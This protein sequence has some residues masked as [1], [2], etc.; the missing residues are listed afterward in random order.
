MAERIEGLSIE[1]D[2]ET[3]K[4]NSGLKDLKSQLTV[5]NSEMKANMSAF[6]RSD[7]SIEKYETRLTGLNKKLEVQRAVV[8]NARKTYEKMVKEHGEGTEEA[9]KAAKEYNNQVASLNNLSRYVE[10]VEGDLAQLREEQRIANS[11]WTKMGGHLDN[12]GNKMTIFGDKV[13]SAGSTMSKTVTPAVLGI[14][15]AAGLVAGSYEDSATRIQNSLGLTAEEAKEL[16]DVSRNIYNDGFGESAEEIDTALLQVKQ[17]IRDV[18]NEDLERI[19]EKAFLLADT[20]ESDVNEVTRAGN[21]IIKGFGI[22]ADEAFDL[23]A[24][25]AQNGLNFSNEMFDNLSEYSGLFASM[26]FS[27]E[28]Y[29][30]LLQKGSEAGIYNLDY[31]NDVMKEF[32]IRVK[33]GSD[34][35]K[36][37]MGQMSDSTQD[38]W[39]EFQKGDKTVKDVSNAVLKELEG[40]DNQVAANQIGV[41]LFG[42]KFEDLESEA[43]YS[44]GGIGEGIE[45]VDGTMDEMTKNAE[46]NIS[47]QWKATWREAKEILL[48]VGETLLDFT[49]EVLP[50][51]K[52]GVEDVTEWFSELDE[53]GKRNIV[54]LGGMAAAAGPVLTVV[55]GLS[56]GIGGLLKVTGGLTTAIGKKNGKG[57]AGAISLLSR[58]GVAGLAIAGVAGI[59]IG[60]AD[61]IKKSKKS[62]EVNLD[63]AQSLSDQAVQLESSAET[64]DKLSGKAKISNDEL[65]ELNDLN[66]R[67]S[68]STNPGEINELQK[69]YEKLAKKSGLSKDEL[70]YLFDANKDIIDQAPNVQH[71]VSESGNAFVENTNAVKEYVNSLYEMSKV[72][73]ENER[74]IALENEREI[75][76]EIKEEKEAIEEVEKKIQL[77]NAASAMEQQEIEKRLSKIKELYN[78]QNVSAKEKE[79]LV[80]EE[81]A[82]RDVLTGKEQEARLDLKGQLETKKES[83][84][85]SEEELEKIKA[86][87][88]EMANII[89]KQVGIN[90]EGEKGL[91]QLDEKLAKNQQELAE[92]DK[93]LEKN[94]VLNEKDRERR[95]TLQEI[96]GQQQE[97]RNYI[98]DELGL[99]N[100]LN[101]LIDTKLGYLDQEQEKRV[102]NLAKTSEIK[103]EEGNILK[104]MDQKNEK[105]LQEREKLIENWKQQGANKQEIQEQINGIDEKILKNDTVLEKI[106]REAGLWDEVKDKIN[107]GT[108]ALEGQG[109]QIDRNNSKTSRGIGLEEER[110]KEAGKDATKNIFATDNGTI[111]VIDFAAKAGLTKNVTVTDNGTIA[112]LEERAK[113]PVQKAIE[114]VT[115]GF[116]LW[117]MGTPPTGHPGGHAILGDGVGSNAGKE[118]VTLPSGKMF[119]SADRPTLYPNLPKGTHVMPARETKKIMRVTPQYAEGTG[120]WQTLLEPGVIRTDFSKLLALLA[121][122][123]PAQTTHSGSVQPKDYTKDLLHATL[124][125]NEILMQLLAKDTAPRIDA[126]SLGKSL[127][128]FITETQTRKQGGKKRFD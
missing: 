111:S 47:Q 23:M 16:T 74:Q 76:K 3:M 68:E 105:L 127:E 89:L 92:L 39:K 99:Y 80:L 126:R 4:I 15:T 8:D 18:N 57:A 109:S 38:V 64:F 106:L 98:Y 1:L 114:F 34:A 19:T 33:D 32:Q 14:G 49:R 48:P 12:V 6:D 31:I 90:A 120:G 61:L 107:F 121:K 118:L 45:D 58:G 122:Q 128:P 96:V 54:M 77:L 62:E 79:A 36:D 101:S 9:K 94:G 78:D 41:E 46:K 37:A 73:L 13:S 103:I 60:V 116:N 110:T 70:G 100:D 17:N 2:L 25:G 75:T 21:N 66:Q 83:I 93:Q 86:L 72:E 35:T 11:N 40:M 42:T 84:A 95:E 91:S 53:E 29:F 27:A 85:A 113:S 63:V 119:L 108:D 81:I 87:D 44:L 28:E 10:R 97:A 123:A 7:K 55:G 71:S 26:G 88:L 117:A 115:S 104:Q 59:T 102:A 22:E 65:A 20:F 24:R 124:Q 52:E 5:V 82:L 30:E 69:Q 67:I 125:Q 43:M 50:D 56:S 112:I 51:V